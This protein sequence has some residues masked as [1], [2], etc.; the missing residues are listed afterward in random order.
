[1]IVEN[2][3]GRFAICP[4][5]VIDATGDADIGALA[6]APTALFGQGNVLAAWYYSHGR[7]GYRLHM[8]GASDIPEA[9]KKLKKAPELLSRRR[10]GGLDGDEISDYMAMSHAEVMKHVLEKRETDDTY[11]PVK[12]AAIP[13]LRMT[14]RVVG[15]YTLDIAEAHREF[16][17]SIGMVS[18]WRHRG[19]VFEIPF[20][21]LFAKEVK[22]LL[23]AGRC[24]SVT[25]AMWDVMRVIPCCAVT[26]EAAFPMIQEFAD[27][28]MHRSSK[29]R[30]K[31]IKIVNNFFGKS[32]TVAGLMTGKDIAEQLE[33]I[34]LG[35]EL[36]IPAN[37]LRHGEDVFLC[38]MTVGEL[39][40]KLATPIRIV[41]PD[42]YSFVEAVFGQGI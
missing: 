26:G 22:N 16:A 10:F 28:L 4:D 18:D 23:F 19:P 32:I 30:V 24:T 17:D 37:A 42:G 40:E 39:S 25:D 21:T 1:V 34:E 27:Y 29:I 38:G 8:R 41:D 20:G 5:M 35:D 36:L 2:K 11:Q 14:R 12:I 7:N 6:G 15:E 9:E 3:S 33:G 13:Q 31:V